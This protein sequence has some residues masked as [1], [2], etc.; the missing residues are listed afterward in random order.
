MNPNFGAGQEH[1]SHL[2]VLRRY[3]LFYG[4]VESTDDPE[5]RQRVKVRVFPFHYYPTN[6]EK[7]SAKK[8]AVHGSPKN[9]ATSDGKNIPTDALPWAQVLSSHGGRP[10]EGEF[11]VPKVGS[12]VIV[13]FI[14]G[15]LDQPVVLGTIYGSGDAPTDVTSA[16][17]DV[18]VHVVSKTPKGH[19]IVLN[20]NDDKL[21]VLIRSTRGHEHY[22][23]IDDVADRYEVLM[24]S[25]HFIEMD[26]PNQ[27][28]RVTTAGKHM[29]EM[30]DP[31]QT[32][33]IT[34]TDGYLI[35]LS[36]SVANDRIYGKTPAGQ[37]WFQMSE[38]LDLFEYQSLSAILGPM[39]LVYDGQLSRIHLGVGI[40]GADVNNFLQGDPN[41]FDAGQG[42]G[43][44]IDPL[45]GVIIA[46]PAV[47][48]SAYY[49]IHL[50]TKTYATTGTFGSSEQGVMFHGFVPTVELNTHV[51]GDVMAGGSDSG[52][53]KI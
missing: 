15:D 38:G 16:T 39:K 14:Q 35:E 52:P 26:D 10:N 21:E 18:L 44:V 48:L 49:D 17:D 37:Q 42:A 11:Q 3:G 2:Q 33:T 4:Y 25:G 34:T 31:S 23:R 40:I 24:Q 5:I 1:E 28:I 12:Q 20:D 9:P 8:K 7:S 32:I 30:D 50:R 41:L 53:P 27:F 51:H 46:G 29:I 45:L 22:I 13:Q 19:K 6:S 36:D 47:V 43:I